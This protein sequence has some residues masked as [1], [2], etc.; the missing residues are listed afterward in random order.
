MTYKDLAALA[1]RSLDEAAAEAPE[2]VERAVKWAAHDAIVNEFKRRVLAEVAAKL[3][4]PP[5]EIPDEALASWRLSASDL[6]D[7]EL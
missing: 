5:A 4:L 2:S 7:L 1:R 6:P 3:D